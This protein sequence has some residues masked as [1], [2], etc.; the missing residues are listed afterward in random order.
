MFKLLTIAIFLEALCALS[1]GVQA[2]TVY[3]CGTTYSQTPCPEAV[4]VKVE[5]SRDAAQ[6][7]Q[8][9][10]VILSNKKTGQ[11]MEK[12]RLAQ[13]KKELADN[14]PITPAIKAQTEPVAKPL[15]KITPK[16]VKPKT[17]QPENFVTQVPGTGKKAA[18]KKAIKKKVAKPA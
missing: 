2:Q 1:T 12:E 16:R 7:K 15:T 4:P 18:P 6:K 5:D 10:A 8:A 11:L 13:E 14:H 17:N 9:D 3:K